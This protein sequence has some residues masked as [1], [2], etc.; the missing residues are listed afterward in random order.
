MRRYNITAAALA[1]GAPRKWT[2]NILSQHDIPD[3]LSVRQGV[4]RRISYP[5]LVRLTVIRQLHAELGIGVSDAI[6]IAA[7]LLDSGQGAVLAV[8]QLRLFI[9]QVAL[10]QAVDARLAMALES[11]PSPK[12]GRPPRKTASARSEHGPRRAADE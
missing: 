6:R 3:V 10:R 8:G 2:D 1:I 4:P 9:D 12:R 7:R 11:A 5:A